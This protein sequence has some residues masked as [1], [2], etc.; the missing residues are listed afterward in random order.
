L[1]SKFQNTQEP[2]P[3]QHDRTTSCVIAQKYSSATFVSLCFHYRKENF[4]P[5]F[6]NVTF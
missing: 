4:S 3:V 5:Y 2:D 6:K 1:E